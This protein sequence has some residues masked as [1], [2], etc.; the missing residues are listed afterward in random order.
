MIRI[1]FLLIFASRNVIVK[2]FLLSNC[3]NDNEAYYE[4]ILTDNCCNILFFCPWS[5]E[6]ANKGGL[7][8]PLDCEGKMVG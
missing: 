6:T 4:N 3:D 5:G 8:D 7:R 1:I 2:H